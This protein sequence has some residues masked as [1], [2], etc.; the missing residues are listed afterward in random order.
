MLEKW[1]PDKIVLAAELRQSSANSMARIV[2]KWNAGVLQT[3]CRA[4]WKNGKKVI[5]RGTD[6]F[7][8]FFG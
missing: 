8:L 3:L 1:H 4:L 2:K 5:I 6:P 7:F